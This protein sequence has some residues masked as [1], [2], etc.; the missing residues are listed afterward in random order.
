[1]RNS[2]L[3]SFVKMNLPGFFTLMHKYGVRFNQKV[4]GRDILEYAYDEDRYDVA[5]ALLETGDSNL[6]RELFR[7]KQQG[8]EY[9]FSSLGQRM[10]RDGK[11]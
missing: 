1:M 10:V 2:V 5:A 4:K 9:Q 11:I 7:I 3:Y 6:T 8:D